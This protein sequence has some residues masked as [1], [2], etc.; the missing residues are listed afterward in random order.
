[1]QNGVKREIGDLG[2]AGTP[3]KIFNILKTANIAY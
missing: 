3:E 1:M 2:D